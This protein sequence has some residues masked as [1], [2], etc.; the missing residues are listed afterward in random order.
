LLNENLHKNKNTKN[1]KPIPSRNPWFNE[2]W[3]QRFG[4]N[5]TTSP[6]CIRYQLNESNWDSKLQFIVDATY[7]FAHALHEYFNCSL[8]SCSNVSLTDIDGK[9]LFQLILEKTFPS[10]FS[11]GIDLSNRFCNV[12]SDGCIVVERFRLILSFFFF[13]LMR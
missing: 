4:C 9:F 10:K 7:V 12:I 11:F 2:F 1:L 6:T 8:T 5:L 13:M 3:E